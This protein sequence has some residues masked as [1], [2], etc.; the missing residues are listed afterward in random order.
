[1]RLTRLYEEQQIGS[2]RLFRT[3]LIVFDDITGDDIPGQ[4]ILWSIDNH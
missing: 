1:M 2:A 4:A 3:V